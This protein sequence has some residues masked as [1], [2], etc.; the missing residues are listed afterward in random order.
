MRSTDSRQTPNPANTLFFFYTRYTYEFVPT[1]LYEIVP[2]M[3]IVRLKTQACEK[4]ALNAWSIKKG[5]LDSII[6]FSSITIFIDKKKEEMNRKRNKNDSRVVLNNVIYC[7]TVRR[8]DL[9]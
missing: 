7:C 9:F 5:K 2:I 1:E 3:K 8:L 4:V 6:H